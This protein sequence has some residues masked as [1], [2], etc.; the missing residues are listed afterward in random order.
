MAKKSHLHGE[1]NGT[2]T[3]G[4]QFAF[5]IKQNHQANRILSEFVRASIENRL[6]TYDDEG[7]PTNNCPVDHQQTENILSRSTVNQL[8]AQLQADIAQITPQTLEYVVHQVTDDT[9]RWFQNSSSSADFITVNQN[10]MPVSVCSLNKT[11]CIQPPG[12]SFEPGADG[13]SFSYNYP[14]LSPTDINSTSVA[15]AQRALYSWVRS[16]EQRKLSCNN[17]VTRKDNGKTIT[18]TCYI[19]S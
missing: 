10:G 12:V 14:L 2:L 4:V 1:K 16:N 18:G 15:T 11:K 19:S 17:A 6:Y 9:A 3:K 8:T 7:C 5:V 13:N